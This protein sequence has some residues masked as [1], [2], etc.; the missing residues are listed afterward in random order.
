MSNRV[1]VAEGDVAALLMLL[2][3]CGFGTDQVDHSHRSRLG[4]QEGP[5][6]VREVLARLD[7]QE[8]AELIVILTALMPEA[9]P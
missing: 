6:T 3:R 8:A 4:W 1:R 5:M 7:K 2:R 9:E